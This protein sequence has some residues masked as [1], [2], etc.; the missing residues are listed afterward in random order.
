MADDWDQVTKI[1]SKARSGASQRETVVRGNAALNAAKRS[2]GSLATEKKYSTGNA[3]SS[4]PPSFPL[5]RHS[6]S[7]RVTDCCVRDIRIF[8]YIYIAFPHTFVQQSQH[9]SSTA[10][11]A[12][13][14]SAKVPKASGSPRWTAATTS[15]SRTRWARRWATSSAR[16]GRRWSPR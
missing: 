1:G 6:P 12:N 8:I 13:I 7:S 14:R 9:K 5:P 11:D 4:S 2:G 10:T 15:S 16:R 3:V